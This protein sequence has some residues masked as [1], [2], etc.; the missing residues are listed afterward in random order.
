MEVGSGKGSLPS[1]AAERLGDV[2]ALEL[3]RELVAI[4]PTNL[5]DPAHGRVE[6]PRYTAAAEWISETARRWG[7]ASRIFDPTSTPDGASEF[8]GIPRPSVIVDLDV[9]GTEWVLI[10]SHYDVVPVPTE[11]RARWQTPPHQLSW[12]SDERLYGRGANDDLGSGVVSALLAMKRLHRGVPPTRN[13]RLLVC[14]DEESGGAGGIEAIKAHDEKL[15]VG[16]PDR[17]I[18]GDVALIPDGSPHVTAGSSGLAFVDVKLER[19]TALEPIVALGEALVALDDRAKAWLSAYPSPDWPEF[20]APDAM[21]TGRATVTMFDLAAGWPESSLGRLRAIH[22]ETDVPNQIAESV[23]LAFDPGGRMPSAVLER[24]AGVV[25]EPFRVAE[26]GATALQ[27]TPG[28]VA[29]SVVGKGSHAGYPHRGHNPV[30]A[31]IGALRQAMETGWIDRGGLY[32]ASYAIDLRLTPEMSLAAGLDPFLGW[33]REWIDA[34][35]VPAQ[36]A[37]PA[38][39][40]RGGY[41]LR[42]DDPNVARLERIMAETLSAQGVFGEYG[43]TDASTLVGL[44]TPGG[45][46]LPAIVFGGM[47]RAA[48][49]HQ[50]EES[51]DPRLLAGVAQTIE[52][53][54]RER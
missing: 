46:P 41:A 30:P 35:A 27:L 3:L 17:I 1:L 11:Q 14:C 28:S 26:T 2:A 13:V 23:T 54:V 36:V 16:S 42:I 51:A 9:G 20:G 52:R 32:N 29:V 45:A 34:H 25:S 7:L 49:I 37:A 15:P 47:D 22:A 18:S 48:N 53:F 44:T 38:S 19:P 4:A 10:L 50:A 43:G 39:R 33:V 21:I 6:K 5:D 40:C 31:V 8:G 12:R 24:F